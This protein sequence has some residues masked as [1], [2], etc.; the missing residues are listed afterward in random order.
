[1]AFNTPSFVIGLLLGL[2]IMLIIV[3]ILY[4]SRVFMFAY[5]PV[6]ARACGSAD[7]YNDPGEAL[8][9][10]PNA[11]ISQMLFLNDDKQMFYK[12]VPRTTDCVTESNQIVHI[13]YPQY[14]EFSN[15]KGSSSTWKETAY[16]SNI[17][18]QTSN[19]NGQSITT[20]GD[21][22]PTNGSPYR[23]GTP[24]LKWDAN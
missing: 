5:C 23:T 3:W 11:D 13:Q 9:E 4:I 7:Y 15:G 10:D 14:C 19:P 8:N 22:I 6:Q 12:R 16:N 20:N 18:R 1:M 2:L 24:L 17:Y 21:C